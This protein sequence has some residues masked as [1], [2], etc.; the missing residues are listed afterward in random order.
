MLAI[1]LFKGINN[2]NIV[3][4]FYPDFNEIP[5]GFYVFNVKM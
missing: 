2:F 1:H 4:I 5:E 3:Y